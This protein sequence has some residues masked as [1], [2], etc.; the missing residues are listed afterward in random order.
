MIQSFHTYI[1]F[2]FMAVDAA[3][4]N[5]VQSLIRRGGENPSSSFRNASRLL[6]SRGGEKFLTVFQSMFLD[7]LHPALWAFA[8]LFLTCAPAGFPSRRA[9]LPSRAHL[10]RQL[11]QWGDHDWLR[12]TSVELFTEL[13]RGGDAVQPRSLIA[14]RGQVAELCACHGLSLIQ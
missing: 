1:S 8:R 2:T 5:I 10:D 7:E 6:F 11:L 9:S 3:V 14:N 12:A 13:G 4:C